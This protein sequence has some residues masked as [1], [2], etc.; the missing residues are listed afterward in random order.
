MEYYR[1]SVTWIL[2]GGGR[3]VA[4]LAQAV[5][6]ECINKG[7]GGLHFRSGKHCQNGDGQGDQEGVYRPGMLRES[8]AGTYHCGGILEL[9]EVRRMAVEF[10]VAGV[11]RKA[12]VGGLFPGGWKDISEEERKSP[13]VRRVA[14]K[15]RLCGTPRKL[16]LG[17]RSRAR[18]FPWIRCL[19]W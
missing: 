14:R 15:M 1:F 6:E 10:G 12:I 11:F 13:F 8:A 2:G 5:T 18:L 3:S 9:D 7:M 16:R 17:F 19:E 4:S